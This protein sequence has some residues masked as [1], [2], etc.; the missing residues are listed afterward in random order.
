M[1][2]RAGSAVVLGVTILVAACGPGSC[3]GSGQSGPR[4]CKPVKDAFQA[5]F[6]AKSTY[7][8]YSRAAAVAAHN[9]REAE[10]S[11]PPEL[12]EAIR[13]VALFYEKT[14]EN[15]GPLGVSHIQEVRPHVGVLG[16]AVQEQCGFTLDSQIPADH[17]VQSEHRDP[18]KK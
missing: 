9:L 13:G 3:V 8:D 5:L 14:V 4:F 10:K 12:A 16:L 11:A 2:R 6:E 7:E 17:P 1:E 18:R 15:R